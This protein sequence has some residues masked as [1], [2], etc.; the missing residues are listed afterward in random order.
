MLSIKDFISCKI[1]TERMLMGGNGTTGSGTC[2]TSCD[3][4]DSDCKD[5]TYTDD[6]DG[7]NRVITSETTS[8]D[9]CK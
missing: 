3:Q 7:S 4:N 5:Y 6:C 2:S 1:S 8:A 9:P